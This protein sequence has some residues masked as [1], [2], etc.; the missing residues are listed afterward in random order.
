MV[1][2][3]LHPGEM[4]PHSFLFIL[5]LCVSL[6]IE[7]F[8]K[9]KDMIQKRIIFIA[10]F[11]LFSANL[12]GQQVGIGLLVLLMGLALF[13]DFSRTLFGG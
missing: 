10:T 2:F 8:M 3:V 6:T 4:Q 5:Y 1:Q 13:N 12:F 11:L 9:E 7:L